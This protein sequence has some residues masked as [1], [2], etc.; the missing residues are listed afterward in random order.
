MNLL[1]LC[2][3][4]PSLL[5]ENRHKYTSVFLLL[6]AG[7]PSKSNSKLYRKNW[8]REMEQ[9]SLNLI[10][11]D[12]KSHLCQSG[13]TKKKDT[14]PIQTPVNPLPNYFQTE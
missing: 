8:E 2:S 5:L 4:S 3:Y 12:S 9:K 6:S 10:K 11:H 13:A 1:P 14:I 7:F